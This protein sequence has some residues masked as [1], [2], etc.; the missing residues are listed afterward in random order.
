MKDKSLWVFGITDYKIECIK[1]EP[2]AVGK[3][4]IVTKEF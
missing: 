1:D 4:L 3:P 2:L